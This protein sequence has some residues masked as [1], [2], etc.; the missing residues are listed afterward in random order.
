MPSEQADI[1]VVHGVR[2][3][4]QRLAGFIGCTIFGSSSENGL[5]LTSFCCR[6]GGSKDDSRGGLVGFKSARE[7]MLCRGVMIRL[8]S[9]G[10]VSLNGCKIRAHVL[11]FKEN[12]TGESLAP[13]TGGTGTG[14]R[15]SAGNRE[16]GTTDFEPRGG[17]GGGA[18]VSDVFKSDADVYILRV[19]GSGGGTSTMEPEAARRRRLAGPVTVNKA[20]SSP[21]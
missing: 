21:S 20:P 19:D 16:G 5:S 14:R 6:A 3:K 10:E 18:R 4:Y 7:D 11:F 12:I 2:R 1:L 15:S 13:D 17:G 9:E 8:G